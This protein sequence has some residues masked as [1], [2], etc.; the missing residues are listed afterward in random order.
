MVEW[1]EGTLFGTIA[2]IITMVVRKQGISG[3]AAFGVRFRRRDVRD[4]VVSG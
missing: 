1:L 2:T 3:Q 4:R